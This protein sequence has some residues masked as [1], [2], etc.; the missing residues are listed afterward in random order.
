MH[1]YGIRPK[2]IISRF[3]TPP[4]CLQEGFGAT[5]M[6]ASRRRP[7][8]SSPAVAPPGDAKPAASAGDELAVGRVFETGREAVQAV[9]DYALRRGKAVRVARSSGADRRL[10]CTSADCGFYV[11]FYRHRSAAGKYGSWYLSSFC[12]EH[13]NC[14]A[15]ARPTR[16]QLIQSDTVRGA[17]LESAGAPVSVTA[18]IAR[19]QERDGISLAKHKRSVYRALDAIN[20]QGL[21]ETRKSF[22]LLPS[23]LSAF[24]RLN[25]GS[26]TALETDEHHRFKRAAVVAKVFADAA[27]ARQS[28]LG[29]DC[30]RSENDS[31]PGVQ[32]RLLG[33][34]GNLERF[35][36]A[37]ALLP[38][39]DVDNMSWFFQV[40]ISAGFFLDGSP[41]ICDRD[42]AS[43]Q[44]VVAQ[45]GMQAKYC[46]RH[47]VRHLAD[48][49]SK[50][51]FQSSTHAPLIWQV[52][53]ADTETNYRNA[54]AR[55]RKEGNDAIADY[56]A[57]IDPA[58]WCVFAN[59]GK[60]SLYGQCTADLLELS[61][62]P[63]D[64]STQD[65]EL[66]SLA[67][68]AFVKR[69]CESLV[70][71]CYR[72][73]ELATLWLSKGDRVTAGA[74]EL[75][76][77]QIG[78]IDKYIVQH[79]SRNLSYVHHISAT[80]RVTRRIDLDA[81]TCTCGF[82]D[83]FRAPCRHVL[84]SLHARKSLEQTAWDYFDG[85]YSVASFADAFKDKAVCV[86]IESEI[87]PQQDCVHPVV[88]PRR[89]RPPS[90]R[91]RAALAGAQDPP[92]MSYQCSG[93]GAN[94]HNK[95]TCPVLKAAAV[96]ATAAA[97]V[98]AGTS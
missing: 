63:S 91:A 62:I 44:T 95:R 1:T 59:A 67:P 72:R 19:V 43:L 26:T 35:T 6:A 78:E 73:S 52:Q 34:D 42:A 49:L 84:A 87:S 48:K 22:A 29:V 68:F 39:E 32:V 25:P 60:A 8:V 11:Q 45:L 18:V 96:T 23:Y 5:R 46:V 12:G 31:F 40:V 80:P 86:P 17:V 93:C 13:A 10:R 7:P 36:I 58:C 30:Q 82:I 33:R 74:L 71:D 83:Q 27:S 70:S 61:S 47:L 16:R 65:H 94:G 38:A 37:F 24:E 90:K 55:L 64:A 81:V 57:A 92:P 69:M 97:Q 53:A 89:G 75:Y 21:E 56:V 2:R 20:D 88:T 98:A 15:V 3:L 51:A 4:F 14:S 50:S 28:L 77:S 41:V 66:L 9:Q 76:Q 85:Y 54:L 79:A